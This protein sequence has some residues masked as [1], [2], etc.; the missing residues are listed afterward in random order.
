MTVVNVIFVTVMFEK[1][2]NNEGDDKL[3]QLISAI[4]VLT[5]TIEGYTT[6]I[7]QNQEVE[8]DPLLTSDQVMERLKFAPT[9]YYRRINSGAIKSIKKGAIIY[10]R[11]SDLDEYLSN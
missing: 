2:N 7:K 10:V 6:A 1:T 5:K 4:N 11:Q 9:T 8:E 3:N